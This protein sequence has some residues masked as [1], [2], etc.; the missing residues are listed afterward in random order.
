MAS[1]NLS[2]ESRASQVQGACIAFFVLSPLFVGARLFARVKVRSWSGL[3]W[4]DGT[5]LAS[6]IFSIIL[7][8]IVMVACASGYGKHI[9]NISNPEEL[10]TVLKVRPE[11]CLRIGV[12]KGRWLTDGAVA[13]LGCRYLLQ[14]LDQHD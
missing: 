4:D 13:C 5:L 7:S 6:W 1:E 14:T 12:D 10:S 2:G 3:S 8:A 9:A 11:C